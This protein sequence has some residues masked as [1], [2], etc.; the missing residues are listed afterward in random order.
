MV[1]LLLLWL[2]VAFPAVSNAAQAYSVTGLGQPFGSGGGTWANSISDNGYV[3]GGGA[4]S[5]ATSSTRGFLW[6]S[7][8]PMQKLG[9]LPGD[10]YS[11][12][13]GVNA[14][15]HVAGNSAINF[16]SAGQAFWFD[17]TT[18]TGLGFLSGGVVSKAFGLNESDKVVGYSQ[19]GVGNA[20][21]FLWSAGTMQALGT[22]PSGTI[23]S[24]AYAINDA[25]VVV[26]EAAE[27]ATSKAF[28]WDSVNGARSL[29]FLSGHND[30]SAFDVN[31]ASEVVGVNTDTGTKVRAVLWDSAGVVHNLGLLPGAIESEAYGINDLGVVVG[32]DDRAGGAWVYDSTNGLRDL[33]SLIGNAT[34]TWQLTAASD[35]NNAGQI[36]GK[37]FYNGQQE[38]FL[39]TPVPE[40]STSGLLGSALLM[41]A[42][43]RRRRCGCSMMRPLA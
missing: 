18:M 24:T 35:I 4:S 1:R 17:G 33:N 25:G 27:L 19:D 21:A 30:G 12:A 38:A 11:M 37:G 42:S 3:V 32:G 40:P 31:S 26:G 16:E 10:S 28:I 36:V 39:L 13:Y 15:G 43:V 14:S 41:T 22:L 29:E 8:G 2:T 6:Q 23:L 20:T 5:D 9:T 7:P 34:N